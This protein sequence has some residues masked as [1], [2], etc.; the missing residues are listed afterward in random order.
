MTAQIPLWSPME[1]QLALN[2]SVDQSIVATGVQFN[3]KEIVA[4]D[5]FIALTGG[6][7]DGHKYVSDALD[8]GAVGCIV[9]HIV[10]GVPPEKQIVVS[11]T[12]LALESLARFAR[13]RTTAQVVAITGSCGKTSTKEML[14]ACLTDQGKTHATAKNFN[15]DLGIPFTLANMPADTQYAVIEMGISHP[16]EMAPLSDLVRP[17]LTLIT[18]IAPAH[19]EFFPDTTAI[20]N[21]KIHITDYQNK[22]GAIIL[23]HDD[24]QYQLLADVATAVGLKKIIRFGSDEKSDIQ[25]LHAKVH[26]SS[27]EVAIRWHG[28]TINY[29][30]QF[31]GQH[32]ALNSLAVLA[33]VD[34]LGASVEQAINT[35]SKLQPVSGR[36][37]TTTI[38]IQ[39]KTIHLIDDAYNANPTSMAASIR[40]LGTHNGRLVAVLGDMLELGE[41]SYEMHLDM[42]ELLAQNNIHKLY[43]VGPMMSRV[44]DLAPPDLQGAKVASALD[45]K[46]T[47]VADLQD[48][49][50]VLFK[51]SHSTGLDPLIQEL[52]GA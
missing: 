21:E 44:F 28:E 12:K 3:S 31:V 24:A 42:L 20:A 37:Q 13:M 34:A 1:I 52:K 46:E 22:N 32:F 19:Q 2:T 36:G 41:K 8:R 18:N 17:D 33:A 39:G 6:K 29:T 30:L 5:L 40:T 16:G 25:L 27:T 45:L 4:G 51:A 49:D 7:T 26:E 50:W 14:A 15:N 35:L 11:D 38:T 47:L 10:E 43:A 9:T 23:N 48:G